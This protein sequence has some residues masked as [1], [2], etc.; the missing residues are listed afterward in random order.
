MVKV[1]FDRKRVFPLWYL[2]LW[3]VLVAAAITN[4]VLGGSFNPL[5][6]TVYLGVIGLAVLGHFVGR[7]KNVTY[8]GS[9]PSQ[10][11]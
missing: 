9:T 4:L 7:E 3:I 2:V 6:L 5:A 1:P 10:A 8:E 11:S